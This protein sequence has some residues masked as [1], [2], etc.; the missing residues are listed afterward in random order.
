MRLRVSLAGFA[1]A[2]ETTNVAGLAPGSHVI[3]EK[4]FGTDLASARAL[5]QTVYAIFDESQVCALSGS[6]GGRR[7]RGSGGRG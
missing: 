1:V 5:N 2:A 4:P 7:C 3:I 6:R